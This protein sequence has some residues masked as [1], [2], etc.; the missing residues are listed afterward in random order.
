MTISQRRIL[1]QNTQ[2]GCI[3]QRPSQISELLTG[4]FTGISRNQVGG[5]FSILPPLSL[6]NK[7]SQAL[8]MLL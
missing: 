3:G 4:L 5:D 7:S 1:F 8:V 2:L 6:S